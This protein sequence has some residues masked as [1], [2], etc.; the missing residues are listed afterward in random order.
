MCFSSLAKSTELQ[1]ECWYWQC[2]DTLGIGNCP[3]QH[4]LPWL[5]RMT[6]PIKGITLCTLLDNYP[7]KVKAHVLLKCSDNG[8]LQ[9]PISSHIRL[10]AGVWNTFQH[11]C[12]KTVW[13]LMEGGSWQSEWQASSLPTSSPRAVKVAHKAALSVQSQQDTHPQRVLLL[14]SQET[15]ALSRQ[16]LHPRVSADGLW[17]QNVSCGVKSQPLGFLLFAQALQRYHSQALH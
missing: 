10:T 15:W 8:L 5:Q 1:G 12:N 14:W 7:D 13:R 6:T 16:I 2:E 17:R 9:Q 3:S 4:I 11:S